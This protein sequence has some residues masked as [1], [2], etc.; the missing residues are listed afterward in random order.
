MKRSTFKAALVLVVAAM[1]LASCD[2]LLEEMYPQ[3]KEKDFQADGITVTAEID[4]ALL[5]KDFSGSGF[6]SGAWICARLVPFYDT[7][8]G[9]YIDWMNVREDKFDKTGLA[10]NGQKL[11]NNDRAYDY[12][13]FTNLINSQWGIIVWLDLDNDNEIDT[14]EPS[15]LASDSKDQVAIDF[16]YGIYQA[17]VNARLEE[18]T[19][20]PA[21]IFALLYG[22][23]NTG[24]TNQL[25]TAAISDFPPAI[26]VN[27]GFSLQG[28]QSSDPDGWIVAYMWDIV[29]NDFGT[30]NPIETGIIKET[31]ELNYSFAAPGFYEF[32]LKVKDNSGEWSAKTKVGIQV[33]EGAVV[34][35]Q[36]RISGTA[37]YAPF[38]DLDD[39]VRFALV[40]RYNRE[41]IFKIDTFRTPFDNIF[42]MVPDGQYFLI[43]WAD[44]DWDWMVDDDEP[45][46]AAVNNTQGL[47][48]EIGADY[49]AISAA[50]KLLEAR[51]DIGE[52]DR[53]PASLLGGMATEAAY[54]APYTLALD[55]QHSNSAGSKII[56]KVWNN[57]WSETKAESDIPIAMDAAGTVNAGNVTGSQLSYVPTMYGQD[58]AEVLLDI[59]NNGVYVGECRATV[60]PIFLNAGTG[61]ATVVVR[62]KDWY[63]RPFDPYVSEASAGSAFALGL[64]AWHE[65]SSGRQVVVKIWDNAWT[66]TV[67]VSNAP[68]YMNADGMVDVGNVFGNRMPPNNM[69]DYRASPNNYW[70]EVLLDYDGNGIYVGTDRSVILP[71]YLESGNFASTLVV[72]NWEWLDRVF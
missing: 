28:Y 2:M 12:P 6:N 18:K 49:F 5:Y 37:A 58:F 46:A 17:A 56:V 19:R 15:N 23:G 51:V 55:A 24:G 29:R 25:P 9:R 66:T 41:F 8:D 11:A 43:G 26:G 68:I 70:A 69:L 36:I 59:D 72:G 44:R 1:G 48:D 7:G 45:A 67:A 40:N 64:R 4:D 52:F 35:R 16:R 53:L 30:I 33:K 38:N 54:A 42:N 3:F 21:E 62:E 20:I 14:D 61:I 65:G 13:T 32:N 60:V 31:A 63:E 57:Y 27:E 47:Y 10:A 71:I 50:T 34:D 22:E 39:P